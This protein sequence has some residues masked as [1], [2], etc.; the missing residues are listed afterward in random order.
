MACSTF[1]PRSAVAFGLVV[2]CYL[3]GPAQPITGAEGQ[4]PLSILS[5]SWKLTSVEVDGE[6]RPIEDDIRWTINDDKVL[7][8]GEPLATITHYPASTPKG[9]D[10]VL[11]EPKTLYEGIYV[12]E[13]GELKICLNTRTVG[14]KERP[15]DFSTMGKSNLRILTFQRLGT[16]DGPPES[17]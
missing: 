3:V 10:L 6:L 8:G 5:G 1:W 11:A 4:E 17:Q 16:G 2:A 7:Y 15:A 9:I 13:Q 12:L 14:T